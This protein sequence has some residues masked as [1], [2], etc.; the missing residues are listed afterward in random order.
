[1]VLTQTSKDAMLESR[2]GCC[3]G[4]SGL[5][6]MLRV[7]SWGPLWTSSRQ[8]HH[9]QSVSPG[10]N[11]STTW[12]LRQPHCPLSASL[13]CLLAGDQIPGCRFTLLNN[14]SPESYHKRTH[15]CL[16]NPASPLQSPALCR[17][18][19]WGLNFSDVRPW[20]CLSVQGAN[21]SSNS[22]L[23]PAV[24][25]VSLL[26]PHGRSFNTMTP[27]NCTYLRSSTISH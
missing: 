7:T 5:S 27:W 21:D 26:N 1:M 19:R 15:V 11:V 22:F 12:G 6:Q 2:Q 24:V 4:H 23:T 13:S 10:N 3:P 25:S 14:P 8:T 20:C 18:W 9:F 16:T 17:L